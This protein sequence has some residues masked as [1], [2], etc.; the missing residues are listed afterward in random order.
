MT[1]A[2]D[3]NPKRENTKNTKPHREPEGLVSQESQALVLTHA[4]VPTKF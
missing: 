1:T 2:A 3:Q 4:K